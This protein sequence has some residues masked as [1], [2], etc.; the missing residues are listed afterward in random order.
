LYVPVGICISEAELLV[1]VLITINL[2]VEVFSIFRQDWVVAGPIHSF[3][4]L[5]RGGIHLNREN[6]THMLRTQA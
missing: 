3:K 4:P 2:S 5:K 1:G 6:F